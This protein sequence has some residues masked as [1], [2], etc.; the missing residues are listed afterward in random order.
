MSNAKEPSKLPPR[1][2]RPRGFLRFREGEEP[3]ATRYGWQRIRGMWGSYLF[4]SLFRLVLGIVLGY[5]LMRLLFGEI[6]GW[7]EE[8]TFSGAGDAFHLLRIALITLVPTVVVIILGFRWSKRQLIR[9][10]LVKIGLVSG[11]LYYGALALTGWL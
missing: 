5:F 1:D 11:F 2:M 7:W 6:L 10:H 3:I 4:D 9:P 8:G